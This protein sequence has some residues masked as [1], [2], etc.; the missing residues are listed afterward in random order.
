LVARA[1]RTTPLGQWPRWVADVL[2]VKT[3]TNVQPKAEESPE[4][5]S[6][7]NIILRFLDETRGLGGGVAECGVFKGASLAAMGLHLAQ[8][9]DPRHVDGFDSFQGFDQSV[10]KDVALGGAPNSERRVGG[11]DGT[12]LALVRGKLS[13]LGLTG[14]VTLHPGWFAD[15]LARL[16]DQRYSFVHLDCD[17]HE[18]YRQTLEYFYPRMV[19]SGVILLDEYDDPPWPG[20]NLAV[21]DFL[22][23]KVER[24]QSVRSDMYIKYFIRKA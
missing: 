22:A 16:P 6:N 15:T 24:L 18:S 23:D 21:D 13:R 10:A 5:G 1:V 2:E 12:S 3:P 20:C 17:I 4:G 11:F 9:A 8:H 14:R 7:I 19:A